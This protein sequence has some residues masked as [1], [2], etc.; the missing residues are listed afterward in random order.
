MFSFVADTGALRELSRTPA[1]L[2]RLLSEGNERRAQA[3]QDLVAWMAW[4][5]QGLGVESESPWRG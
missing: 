2:E 3:C 4:V 5:P 1:R